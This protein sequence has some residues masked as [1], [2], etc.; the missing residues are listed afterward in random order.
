MLLL[1]F[2][3]VKGGHY[4]WVLLNFILKSFFYSPEGPVKSPT[5]STSLPPVCIYE[6]DCLHFLFCS[7]GNFVN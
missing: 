5:S 2:P 3:K 4:F 6:G 7:I 1:K